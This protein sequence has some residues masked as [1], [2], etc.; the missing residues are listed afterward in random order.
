MAKH[1]M[2]LNSV[3]PYEARQLT[4][5]AS[6]QELERELNQPRVGPGRGCGHDSE[7]CVVAGAADGI[8]R[9]K[10]RAIKKVKDL[11]AKFHVEAFVSVK[12]N[13]LEYREIEVAHPVCAQCGVDARFVTKR[14]IR[15]SSK[16]VRIKPL[17]QSGHIDPGF[18]FPAARNY[19]RTR[20]R[21]EQCRVV[22]LAV[23]EDQREPS[24]KCCNPVDAPPS[25]EFIQPIARVGK[26]F[27]ALPEGQIKDVTD[28]QALRN[29]LRKQRSLGAQIVIVLN[30]SHADLQP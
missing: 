10:L 29:I 20:P 14:K 21:S 11:H 13:F 16:A 26:I 17:I 3:S 23:T 22:G 5:L 7:I 19:I 15:G 1:P 2:F 28:H 12:L 18:R 27:P 8:W 6:E 24:L 30:R 4:R 25:H 9:S